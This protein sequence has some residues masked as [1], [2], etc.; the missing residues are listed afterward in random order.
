MSQSTENSSRWLVAVQF[1]MYNGATNVVRTFG[2]AFV[3]NLALPAQQR[4]PCHCRS[5]ACSLAKCADARIALA[6]LLTPRLQGIRCRAAP[7]LTS[8]ASAVTW[9]ISRWGC[10]ITCAVTVAPVDVNT[11]YQRHRPVRCN[12]KAL[13][14]SAASYAM[15]CMTVHFAI[16]HTGSPPSQHCPPPSGCCSESPS[17]LA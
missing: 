8:S 2:G 6:Q 3:P 16:P 1:T 4:C 10:S 12:C 15:R 5:D 13:Q 14:R 11:S 7:P 17:A 9:E